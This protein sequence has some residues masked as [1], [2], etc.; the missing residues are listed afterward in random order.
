[1]TKAT[2]WFRV[3]GNQ[4]FPRDGC[5]F[6]QS[7]NA[8]LAA[9]VCTFCH[10]SDQRN[11]NVS[12]RVG[13]VNQQAHIKKE[14]HYRLTNTSVNAIHE[15]AVT[16]TDV[17]STFPSTDKRSTGGISTEAFYRWERIKSWTKDR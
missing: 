5:V 13:R 9:R 8:R 10:F 11:G 7:N 1:M 2:D 15:C 12:Y 16:N 14:K 3:A 4:N 6:I 17:G